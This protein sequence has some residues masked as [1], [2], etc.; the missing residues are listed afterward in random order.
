MTEQVSATGPDGI[1]T[2]EEPS[3]TGGVTTGV[4]AVDRV[5]RDLDALDDAP[6]E[7]HLPAF[8]RAHESLRS[9]LDAPSVDPPDDPA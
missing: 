4:P 9:A 5:L 2:A 1:P 3:T 6:L 8:E 7:E